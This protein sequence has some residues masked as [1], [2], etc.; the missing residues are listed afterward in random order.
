MAILAATGQAVAAAPEVPCDGVDNVVATGGSANGTIGACPT[1]YHDAVMPLEA[2]VGCD[3]TCPEPDKDG[4]GS[5]SDE[6]PDDLNRL[7]VPGEYYPCDAGGGAASG[8]KLANS[9]GTFGSCVSNATPLCEAAG[10]DN[11]YYVSASGSGSTCSYASPCDELGMVAGGSPGS[12]PGSAK[13]LGDGDVVYIV[14]T[15]SLATTY[16]DGSRQVLAHFT[17]AGTGAKPITVKRYPGATARLGDGTDKGIYVS[18]TAVHMRFIGFRISTDGG[19]DNGASIDSRADDTTIERVYFD[20]PQGDGNDNHSAVYA[21]ASSRL[22]VRNSFFKDVNTDVAGGGSVLNTSGITIINDAGA[23]TG[24]DHSII[25]VVMW[26]TRT[27]QSA[28]SVGDLC[29]NCVSFKHGVILAEAGTNEVSGLKCTWPSYALRIYTAGVYFHNSLAVHPA[30]GHAITMECDSGT[31]G[32][33]CDGIRLEDNTIFNAGLI[34][35][36]PQYTQDESLTI[37]RNV[38]VDDTGSYAAD[39]GIV[40]IAAYGSD[41]QFTQFASDGKIAS[42][43]NNCFYNASLPVRL[44]YFGVASGG[45]GYG[46]AGNAGAYYTLAAWNAAFGFDAGSV[47]EDPGFDEFYRATSINCDDKGYLKLSDEGLPGPTPTPTASPSPTPTPVPIGT[48]DI[49]PTLRNQVRI[50]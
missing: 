23:N 35:W 27:T 49:G 11:C 25:N 48:F 39:N 20:S 37:L 50:R 32:E 40:R 36:I 13:T 43:D 9:D 10:G 47:E 16:S 18:G 17:S 12:P 28:C 3:L 2:P 8:Y 21:Q 15:G 30:N 41:A 24:G 44:N 14:G 7:I 46:P 26:W 31:D 6:D 22:T 29:G 38:I 5:P 33:G 4:D 34:D 42:S 1:G 45:G 19:V